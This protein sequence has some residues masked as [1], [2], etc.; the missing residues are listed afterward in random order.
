MSIFKFSNNNQSK[1]SHMNTL[2]D[3]YQIN[4]NLSWESFKVSENFDDSHKRLNF[5]K[6]EYLSDIFITYQE[7]G[8]NLT[9]DTG[10]KRRVV[11]KVNECGHG[12]Y[13]MLRDGDGYIVTI[14]NDD[15]GTAQM[16]AKPVRLVAATENYLVFRGHEVLAM[17]P[18]GL[19]DPG[20]TDYGFAIFLENGYIKK[21]ALYRYDTKKCYEYAHTSNKAVKLPFNAPSSVSSL[22]RERF[23]R[24]YTNIDYDAVKRNVDAYQKKFK[25]LDILSHTRI[26]GET[27]RIFNKGVKFWNA[28]NKREALKYFA[29]ALEVYPLNTDVIGIYGDYY[30]YTDYDLSMKFYELAISL[31]SLRKKDYFQLA[32]FYKWKGWYDKANRCYSLWELVKARYGIDD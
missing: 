10:R 6:I 11:I 24:D 31:G 19:M 13:P 3:N 17:G 5:S 2:P 26:A 16:G 25:S 23:S 8:V 18:F 7:G 30:E 15:S 12:S 9:C 4:E 29:E 27:D 21:V 1:L 32:N 20:N 22:L 28:G 14:Y